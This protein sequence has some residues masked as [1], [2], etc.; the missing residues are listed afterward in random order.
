MTKYCPKCGKHVEIILI[1]DEG[2]K[3]V[4]Q[5]EWNCRCFFSPC[6]IFRDCSFGEVEEPEVQMRV[7]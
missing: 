3:V 7:G 4:I 5:E 2:E 1:R 6:I